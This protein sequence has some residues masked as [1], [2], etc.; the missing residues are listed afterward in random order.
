[1]AELSEGFDGKL[2]KQQTTYMILDA[3]MVGIAAITLS[4]FHPGICFGAYWNLAN[5]NVRAKK[6]GRLDVEK[7]APTPPN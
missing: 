5:F 6:Q 2:A 3:T 7:E 1:M 4:I